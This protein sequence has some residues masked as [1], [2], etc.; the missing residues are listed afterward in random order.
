MTGQDIKFFIFLHFFVLLNAA[1]PARGTY[2]R[3]GKEN[4]RN[5]EKKRHQNEK[6]KKEKAGGKAGREKK[7]GKVKE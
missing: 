2:S 5:N 1:T 6:V 3:I 4:G 7:R